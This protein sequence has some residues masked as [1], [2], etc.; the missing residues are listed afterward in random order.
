MKKKLYYTTEVFGDEQKTIYV[1]EIVGNEPRLLEEIECDSFN[2]SEDVI[3]N[4][5]G[6]SFKTHEFIQ[7]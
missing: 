6:I 2:S 1:Y 7:L 3:C 5:L 4:E